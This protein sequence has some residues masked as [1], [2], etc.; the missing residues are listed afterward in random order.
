MIA[1]LSFLF[2]ISQTFRFDVKKGLIPQIRSQEGSTVFSAL[3]VTEEYLVYVK[4]AKCSSYIYLPT[5]YN[6]LFICYIIFDFKGLE[7]QNC[8]N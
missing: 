1:P 4:E 7:N 3:L 6:K 2:Q 8:D 5:Q